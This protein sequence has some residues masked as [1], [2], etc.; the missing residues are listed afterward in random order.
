MIRLSANTATVKS[1]SE[2]AKQ[3]AL[4]LFAS[5]R[6]NGCTKKMLDAF[7][8]GLGNAYEINII[9]CYKL[10]PMPCTDC[11]LCKKTDGCKFD[12]LDEY[13]RLLNSAELL[14]VAT[15]VYNLSMPSPL[16]AVADRSQRYFNKRFSL[17][18]KPPIKKHKEA[19]LLMTCGSDNTT[20]FEI[21]QKQFEQMFTIINTTLSA[22]VTA[23]GTDK[24]SDISK[25]TDKA[26]LLGQ[27]IAKK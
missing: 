6:N 26:Y 11:G 9:D 5:P 10:S 4:V 18:I 25:E 17:G 23:H 7:L 12:D 22:V 3:T 16:K 2:A 8:D 13:D 21:I 14:V 20:G 24:R 15:P 1:T 19:V 27:A